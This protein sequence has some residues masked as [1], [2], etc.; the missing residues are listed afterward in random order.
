MMM[1]MMVIEYWMSNGAELGLD[2]WIGGR[3]SKENKDYY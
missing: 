3:L 1:M 2:L